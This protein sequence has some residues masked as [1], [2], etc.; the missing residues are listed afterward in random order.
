[1]NGREKLVTGITHFGIVILLEMVFGVLVTLVIMW[2]SRRRG[3]KADGAI[4]LF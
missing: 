1:L 3:F 2:F 4:S